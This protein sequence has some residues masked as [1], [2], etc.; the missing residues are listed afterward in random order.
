MVKCL[1]AVI[2]TFGAAALADAQWSQFAANG[3]HSGNAAL[4]AQ[5]PVRRLADVTYDPYVADEIDPDNGDL[6]Y[7]YAAPVLDGDDV[8]VSIKENVFI[9]PLEPIPQFSI[10]R[11][12]WENGL[13]AEK[14]S[15]RSDW[16]AV[17]EG[18]W[19]PPMQ[20]I[21]ANGFIYAPGEGGTLLQIDRTSG[22][23]V[24][25]INPFGTSIDGTIYLSGPPSADAGGNIVYGA[26]KLDFNNPWT[27]DVKGAWLVRITPDGT[28][29]TVDFATLLPDAPA[30]DAQCTYLFPFS[31]VRHP[32]SPTAVAPTTVCGS[33]RPGL[34]VV[35]AIAPD[36]TIYIVSRTHLNNRWGYLV[37]VNPD[38]TV[39]WSASLR[40]RFHDGCDVLLPAGVCPAGT[41]IG[42]D[43]DDNLPGSGVV[44]DDSTS[45]P[46]VLPDRSIIYG[47]LTFYN[48][49]SGHLMHFTADGA[50]LGAY[51][52]GWDTTPAVWQH[53]GTFSIVTKENFY[54]FALRPDPGDFI[55]QLDPQ[56]RVEWQ[57]RNP[58]RISC[59]AT[60]CVTEDF[61]FEWCV[62]SPAIDAN[63]TVHANAEDGMV[64]AIAQGGV[65][66]TR[67]AL[68]GPLGAAYTPM[69]IDAEGRVYA[70]NG[71]HLFAVGGSWPK[72]RAFRAK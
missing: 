54:G 50:Y 14:W 46:V 49:S 13:L 32:P 36:G 35:P 68:E 37:A 17:P 28:A 70:Q 20:P 61:G 44:T 10:H 4:I 26:L 67:L 60:G 63:G 15:A 27:S 71:G 34:N 47:A 43:P 5:P 57:F 8:F 23:I 45:S 55:T 22:D 25:R 42:V 3:Q 1:F 52:F 66:Y 7:H 62:N 65:N 11:F 56:L 58:S 69:A 72:R 29:R 18:P 48:N 2:I 39:K 19:R 51:P 41:A 33:Q 53:D 12:H 64:Y 38:L 31:T 6:Y 24:R 16:Y 40:N 21:L 59:R 9:G 30:A